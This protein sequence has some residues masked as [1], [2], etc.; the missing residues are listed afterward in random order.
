MP[1][2]RRHAVIRIDQAPISCPRLLD[3]G[4]SVFRAA[5]FFRH[6]DDHEILALQAVEHFAAT[7]ASQSD[8]LTMT[9]RWSGTLSGRADRTGGAARP[10]RSGS[11]K[12]GAVVPA[13]AAWRFRG[14][15]A[16]DPGV[17]AVVRQD[18]VCRDGA[19]TRPHRSG[20]PRSIW[21]CNGTHSA[22]RHRPSG[23]KVQKVARSFRRVT[24]TARRWRRPLHRHGRTGWLSSLVPSC[25]DPAD[26]PADRKPRF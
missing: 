13:S 12:S 7:R 1:Y 21:G 4:A 3:P 24:G 6:G 5:A 11:V 8:S 20:R 17:A 19:R 25:A 2:K 9:P 14:A 16:Q 18:R 10:A 23:F 15:C 26:R 22:S